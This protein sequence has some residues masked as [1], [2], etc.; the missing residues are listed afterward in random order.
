MEYIPSDMKQNAG[1][2]EVAE[3]AEVLVDDDENASETP[4]VREAP[5]VRSSAAISVSPSTATTSGG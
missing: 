3:A 1:L 4:P 5:T 2:L